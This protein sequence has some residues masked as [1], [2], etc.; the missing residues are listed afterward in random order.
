MDMPSNNIPFA[1][2]DIHHQI[3]LIDQLLV[4]HNIKKDIRGATILRNDNRTMR[5]PRL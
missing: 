5:L 2:I 3:N 4:I 1:R